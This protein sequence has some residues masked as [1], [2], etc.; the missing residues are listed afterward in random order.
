MVLLDTNIFIYLAKGM[1]SAECIMDTDIA[2][3]SITKIE[4]LGFPT[5]PARELLLLSSLFDE[6]QV[7][8]LSPSI[9]ANAI[10][11]KQTQQMNLEDAIIAATALDQDLELWTVNIDDFKHLEDLRVINPLVST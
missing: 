1:L 9:V 8:D 3:A 7:L 5:I 2:Y 6:S 4:A 11:L 10:Q